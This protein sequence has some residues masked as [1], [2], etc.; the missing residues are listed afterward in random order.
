MLR[1][2]TAALVAA[3]LLFSAGDV[4]AQT[5]VTINGQGGCDAT[6]VN[7]KP[8]DIGINAPAN[9]RVVLLVG[10][11]EGSIPTAFGTVEMGTV[12]LIVGLTVGNS[13]FVNIGCAVP[14]NPLLNGLTT[15]FQVVS[16][17]P[18]DPGN[19]E[20]SARTCV[21]VLDNGLCGQQMATFTQGGWGVACNG[22][23]PGCLRD[24]HFA[25]VFG[26]SG[27]ILG[28]PDGDD[29]DGIY[30]VQ[31]TT[32]LAVEILL[33]EGGTASVL[34]GDEVDQ[35]SSSGGV[36]IGQLIAATL[37]LAFD[38]AGAL[39]GLKTNPALKLGDLVYLS[40]VHAELIG[41]SVRD[42]IAL[43][44]DVVSGAAAPPG[45][46]TLSDI[47]DALAVLNENF[48]NGTTDNGNIGLAP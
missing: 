37:N 14:C 4:S 9:W 13:G 36:L 32:S 35:A 45:S 27:M 3:L 11:N 7:G 25:S 30:A 38:D 1:R 47:A 46:L 24:T 33:P 40:G 6:T 21:T 18:Q 2:T 12:D 23:N 43:A 26:P 31:L 10:L 48:D 5:S 34:S 29:V 22:N 41:E 17:D 19:F 20:L 28:D 39:D 42:V 15:Y 44:N 16:F 8:I